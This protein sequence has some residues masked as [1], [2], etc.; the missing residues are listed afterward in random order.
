[1]H[2]SKKDAE[3]EVGGAVWVWSKDPWPYAVKWN[4]Y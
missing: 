1:M 4:K 2:A 3:E